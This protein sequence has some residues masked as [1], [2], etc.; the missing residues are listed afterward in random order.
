MGFNDKA[1][2]GGSHSGIC[3]EWNCKMFFVKLVQLLG[4]EVNP[5]VDFWE[6]VSC[7]VFVKTGQHFQ[8][9]YGNAEVRICIKYISFEIQYFW[10]IFGV[11]LIYIFSVLT[12]CDIIWTQNYIRVQFTRF[13]SIG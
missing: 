11:F 3:E 12:M 5:N 10:S 2:N 1:G 9:Y 6:V 13:Y 8:E 4:T 7:A